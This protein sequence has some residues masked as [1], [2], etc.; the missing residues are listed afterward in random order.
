MDLSRCKHDTAD[1]QA[2][3]RKLFYT[4]KGLIIN[5]LPC[6]P[7]F[8]ESALVN[9]KQLTNRPEKLPPPASTNR[10]P[11]PRRPLLSDLLH[12]VLRDTPG[13][14]KFLAISGQD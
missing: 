3:V 12:K 13:N 9:S 10:P 6:L 11:L 14:S 7:A 5:H 1:K 4:Q 8:S 2:A